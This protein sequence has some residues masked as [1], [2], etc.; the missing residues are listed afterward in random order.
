M[1][2]PQQTEILD[3]L[4]SG[5]NA[6]FKAVAQCKSVDFGTKVSYLER[7]ITEN[8][9][10]FLQSLDKIY[11]PGMRGEAKEENLALIRSLKLINDLYRDNLVKVGNS[12]EKALTHY[13]QSDEKLDVTDIQNMIR[14]RVYAQIA[15]L[16]KGRVDAVSWQKQAREAAEASIKGSSGWRIELKLPDNQL[17]QNPQPSIN[18]GNA[19]FFQRPNAELETL[20]ARLLTAPRDFDARMARAKIL[21]R[22][23]SAAALIDYNFIVDRDPGNI[24]ARMGRAAIYAKE[25][26][27]NVA[28]T[29]Y[30]FVLEKFPANLVARLAR[31]AIYE[32]EN[33]VDDAK[34]DYKF[35]LER[36]PANKDARGGLERIS[37]LP[38]S[39]QM[40]R[41]S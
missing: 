19:G 39:W 22:T 36:N 15:E 25:N 24:A 7:A 5:D 3:S 40:N 12:E 26:K 16:T 32:R 38:M 1:P 23:N 34:Q 35:V 33:K 28:L 37:E 20:N 21:S 30:D 29:D 4:M 41:S 14:N 9:K 13:F 17:V 6:S 31:A 11:L 18:R 8:G 10:A 27:S 2:N